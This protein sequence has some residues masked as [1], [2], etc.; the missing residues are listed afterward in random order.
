MSISHWE[1]IRPG[2]YRHRRTET[3]VRRNIPYTYDYPGDY[4]LRSTGW[5]VYYPNGR[6]KE[7]RTLK[8][9]KELANGR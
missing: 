3:V 5:T 9:G 1:R 8:E 6:S 7:C 4:D 2:L